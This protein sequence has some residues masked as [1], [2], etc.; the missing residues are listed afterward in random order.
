MLFA[1]PW[2][3]V[4]RTRR[5]HEWISMDTFHSV[6]F[7]EL[8]VKSVWKVHIIW[9]FIPF[10]HLPVHESGFRLILSLSL[11]LSK[12]K[13]VENPQL[14]NL[15]QSLQL[16][17]FHYILLPFSLNFLLP[18]SCNCLNSPTKI[19]SLIVDWLT[20]RLL[21]N[22]ASETMNVDLLL[23]FRTPNERFSKIPIL[24][25]FHYP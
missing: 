24:V 2:A 18:T 5:L 11:S 20:T 3:G 9:N 16:L 6:K 1:H 23:R 25:T 19:F 8:L 13:T 12:T 21:R 4:W 15:P 17:E 10:L 14:P 7:K 22:R